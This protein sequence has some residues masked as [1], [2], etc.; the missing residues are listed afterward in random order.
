MARVFSAVDI[1]DEE[2]LQNLERIRNRLDLGFSPVSRQKMHLTLEFF[3]DINEDQIE[4]VEKSLRH[5]E[6]EPFEMELRGLGAFPSEDYIRVVWTGVN[7]HKIFDLQKQAKVHDVPSE[8]Q[9]EFKPHITFLRVKDISQGKKRKLK[10][11]LE[12]HKEDSF[13]T[14]E[15]DSVKLFESRLTGKGS[16]YREISEFD[17]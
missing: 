13:G 4:K 14:V 16:K 2:I 5:I 11:M 1:E 15:V 3:E 6:I 10:K 7:S 17:L 8:N 9:H 12:D